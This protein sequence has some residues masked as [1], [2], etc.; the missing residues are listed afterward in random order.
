[1]RQRQAQR[2]SHRQTNPIS[3]RNM[4]FKAARHFDF[5]SGARLF[6]TFKGFSCSLVLKIR[7]PFRGQS[8]NEQLCRDGSFGQFARKCGV[9]PSKMRCMILDKENYL[10]K[11]YQ[12]SFFKKTFR[13]KLCWGDLYETNQCAFFAG[14]IAVCLKN[15]L[16]RIIK[17]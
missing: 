12:Q 11:I 7:A 15:L 6:K 2:K 16:A 13:R 9:S 3:D 4:S 10:E 14:T 17:F 8:D 5:G 1:M